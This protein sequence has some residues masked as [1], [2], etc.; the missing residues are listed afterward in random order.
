MVMDMPTRQVTTEWG[1]VYARTSGEGIVYFTTRSS[2]DRP[3]SHLTI[4]GIQYS[5][6]ATFTMDAT[7][8]GAV[9]VDDIWH[10]QHFHSTQ[11][12]RRYPTGGPATIA[13]QA[14]VEHKVIPKLVEWLYSHEATSLHDEGLKYRQ[15]RSREQVEEAEHLLY[16]V[17]DRVRDVRASLRTGRR[18]T[19]D[20]A[21]LLRYLTTEFKDAT[22]PGVSS[23]KAPTLPSPPAHRPH[24]PV[25]GHEAPG[26]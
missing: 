3:A 18:L 23:V 2:A 7:A 13:A 12:L 5:W 9:P 16:N 6:S 25:P 15:A 11:E 24:R 20:D 17:L 8:R 26:L 4:N 10:Y 14:A 1:V 19:T 22:A 21:S